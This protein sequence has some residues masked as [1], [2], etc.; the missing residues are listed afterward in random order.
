[1][2]MERSF[3]NTTGKATKK[4][5]TKSFLNTSLSLSMAHEPVVLADVGSSVAQ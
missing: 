5:L 1:M 2:A 4:S 3:K